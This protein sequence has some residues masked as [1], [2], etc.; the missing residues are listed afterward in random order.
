[1]G[2]RVSLASAISLLVPM[3][4]I[5]VFT[6]MYPSLF[7]FW[8]SLLL[9]HAITYSTLSRRWNSW[10]EKRREEEKEEEEGEKTWKL[11]KAQRK[12]RS[13]ILLIAWSLFVFSWMYLLVSAVHLQ[14]KSILHPPFSIS[15]FPHL[16]PFLS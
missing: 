12:L 1:M 15:S 3:S 9:S 16:P 7:R 6:V 4:A 11:K 5:S 8:A 2:F 13:Q 10:L 14:R